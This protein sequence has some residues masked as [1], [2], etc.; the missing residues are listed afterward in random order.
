M[1]G[2]LTL[3]ADRGTDAAGAASA[4]L[5]AGAGSAWCSARSAGVN[6]SELNLMT[7]VMWMVRIR[8]GKEQ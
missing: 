2:E 6:E 4:V 8:T 1:S 7:R 3:T 5:R